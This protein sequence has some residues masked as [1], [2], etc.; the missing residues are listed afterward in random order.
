[1]NISKTTINF[2][3][4]RGLYVTIEE[5]NDAMLLFVWDINNDCEWMFSYRVN[6]DGSF[7]WNDNVYLPQELKEELPATLKDEKH[8]RE[9][10]DY[11]GANRQLWK[12]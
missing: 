9:M 6:N 8:V 7:T 4:R 5:I 12:D 11:V 3:K 10:L 1:M 2:A